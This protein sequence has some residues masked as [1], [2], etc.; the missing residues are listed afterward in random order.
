MK[1]LYSIWISLKNQWSLLKA[2][3]LCTPMASWRSPSCASSPF[4]SP[5]SHLFLCQ[6]SSTSSQLGLV[7]IFFLTFCLRAQQFCFLAGSQIPPGSATSTNSTKMF[8]LGL[9]SPKYRSSH[10]GMLSAANMPSWKIFAFPKTLFCCQI[11]V[12]L[13]QSNWYKLWRHSIPVNCTYEKFY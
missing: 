9:F 1:Y 12:L 8:Y 13:L 11:C 2:I 5:F 6:R 10:C 7:N 3:G 4:I